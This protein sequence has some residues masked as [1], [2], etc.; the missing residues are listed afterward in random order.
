MLMEKQKKVLNKIK[1][2]SGQTTPLGTKPND[3]C[4]TSMQDIINEISRW[5]KKFDGKNILCPCDWDIVEDENI[6]SLKIDFDEENIHGH[7]NTI[8]SLEYTLFD[9]DDNRDNIKIGKKKIDDFLREQLKCNF[10]RTFVEYAKDWNIKSITASGYNPAI[11]KGIKFQEVDFKKYDI[12]VTNPPFSMYNEFI[13]KLLLSKIDFI[14]LAPFLNRA[15]PSVG[16]NLML[17]KCYL[18]YG[19]HLSLN[20]Y[21]PNVK[22]KYKIKIV[23]CDWITSF[24]EA[25]KEKD[26]TRLVNGIKYKDYKNDYILMKNM[27]MK[28]GTNPIK[29]GKYTAIPDDY[30]GWIFCSVGVLDVLSND[31]FEWYGTNFRAYFNQINPYKNPFAHKIFDEMV[32]AHTYI[33]N[34]GKMKQNERREKCKQL[35]EK[36]FHGI[37]LRRKNNAKDGK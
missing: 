23:G 35:K 20:F 3:E 5:S 26:K 24:K 8:K 29:V 25:Q 37:I 16:L 30:Y 10:I 19:R 18:G 28:D 34:F 11:G 14:V 13:E 12:C 15:N 22:N 36:G 31:E 2:D 7:T 21:N 6:F 9:T 1:Y 32:T 17:K 4:Y 27:K 33:K